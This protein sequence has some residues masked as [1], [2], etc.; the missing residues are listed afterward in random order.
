MNFNISNHPILTGITRTASLTLMEIDV[1]NKRLELK[2]KI[3]HY[4]D[5]IH[6]P[7]LVKDIVSIADNN[8]QLPFPTEENPDATIGEFDYW[9][10]AYENHTPLST[11][12]Q[13]GIT[14]ID[15]NGLINLKCNYV[16]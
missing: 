11:M 13:N 1:Q 15:N 3:N 7:E 12:L 4:L 14:N 5:N 16:Q 8:L 10:Y 6:I 2:L 9:M